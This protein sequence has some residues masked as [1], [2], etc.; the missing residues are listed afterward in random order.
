[1]KT[2]VPVILDVDGTAITARGAGIH[3]ATFQGTAVFMGIFA[4]II[5]PWEHFMPS[6]ADR[7]PLF[8]KGDSG[9]GIFRG[10][11]TSVDINEHI[12]I[13]MFQELVCG[14][15]VMALGARKVD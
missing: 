12:D 5:S 8:V 13:P 2:Q 6:L 4:R 15:V 11:C 14:D 1:M 10:F 9:W 7:A 3:P